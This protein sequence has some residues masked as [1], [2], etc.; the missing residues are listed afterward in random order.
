[1]QQRK[2]VSSDL[3]LGWWKAHEKISLE[4]RMDPGEQL[5][6]TSGGSIR[7]HGER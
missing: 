2:G 5:A 7:F 3:I 6:P 1:M 4:G